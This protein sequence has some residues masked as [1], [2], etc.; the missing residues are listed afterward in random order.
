M[1]PSY[2]PASV[3]PTSDMPASAPDSA[4][5]SPPAVGGAGGAAEAVAPAPPLEAPPPAA[6]ARVPPY[7]TESPKISV[8][9]L[10]SMI[11]SRSARLAVLAGLM[12][13]LIGPLGFF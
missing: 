4:L 3:L 7:S 13:I 12:V 1:P 9:A 8:S 6:P 11:L 2:L 10:G 5:A